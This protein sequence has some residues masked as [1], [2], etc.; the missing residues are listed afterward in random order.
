M[1]IE[2]KSFLENN[3]LQEEILVNQNL[4]IEIDSTGKQ[5]TIESISEEMGLSLDEGEE[6]FF[7]AI[8]IISVA[9][10]VITII[11]FLLRMKKLY[12]PSLMVRVKS[13]SGRFIEMTIEDSLNKIVRDIKK[14]V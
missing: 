2:L 4:N 3:D 7:S 10:S 1:D 9:G 8:E 6:Q 14:N 13:I 12:G 5:Q 11:D